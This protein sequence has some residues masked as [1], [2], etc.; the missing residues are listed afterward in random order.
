LTA[1]LDQE[2]F[3]QERGH[4]VPGDELAG[5][6]DEEHPIG[7]AIPR[8][9]DVRL[10]L[11]HP[12]DDV[13]AVLLDQGIGFVVG[14]GAVDLHAQ[15]GGAARQV[16]EQPRRD[17]PGDAAA[18]IEHDVEGLDDRRID[19]TQHLP[20]V[21]V[22]HL[23]LRQAARLVGFRRQPAGGDHVADVA[24]AGVAAERE[25]LAPHHLDAVVFLRV[26]RRGDL[27]AAVE[28]V[29]RHRVIHHVGAHHPVVDD[30]G[31]LGAG[32]LDEGRRH[33]GGRHPHVARHRNPLRVEIRHEPP[34]DLPGR[35]FVDLGRV[36][37]ADVVRLEDRRID[38]HSLL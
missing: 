10:L 8:D 21:V 34:A 35:L 19:E 33:R 16:L 32:A 13:A 38:A 14:E 2:R 11:L 30:V 9:P 22:Q 27:G 36:E 4:E 25:R 15:A 24:D 3:G 6:V 29:A 18:G 26:V 5:A 17:H 37:P 1:L 23:L 28:A 7:V 12:F 20:D 31:A